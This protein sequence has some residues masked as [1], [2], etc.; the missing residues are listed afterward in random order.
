MYYI[1]KRK[2]YTLLSRS[3]NGHKGNN[4]NFNVWPTLLRF[5]KNNLG[6]YNDKLCHIVTTTYPYSFIGCFQKKILDLDYQP[7]PNIQC[8]GICTYNDN[9]NPAY[10]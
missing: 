9:F 6:L 10:T 5:D 4:N 2:Y 3:P 1:S 8:P 7:M